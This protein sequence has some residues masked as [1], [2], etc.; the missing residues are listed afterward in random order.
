VELCRFYAVPTPLLLRSASIRH[1]LRKNVTMVTGLND[2]LMFSITTK[3][4][5]GLK[6]D[7]TSP[8]PL[9]WPR[10]SPLALTLL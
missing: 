5:D 9:R 7:K 3:I 1:F 8:L 4:S 6:L 10:A 2:F